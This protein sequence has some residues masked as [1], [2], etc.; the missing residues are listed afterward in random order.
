MPSGG[1]D[2]NVHAGDEM[3]GDEHHW[4]LCDWCGGGARRIGAVETGM[5]AG[6]ASVWLCIW[7]DCGHE[8]EVMDGDL[9]LEYWREQLMEALF[10]RAWDVFTLAQW[11]RMA[12]MGWGPA[13]LREFENK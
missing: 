12:E 5:L 9:P 1:E 11:N 7:E 4:R 8:M 2:R 10:T 6:H 13:D 3:S